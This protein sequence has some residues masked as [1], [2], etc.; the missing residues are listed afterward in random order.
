MAKKP[1]D[2]IEIQ[3][4]ALEFRNE[5]KTVLLAS[6]KNSENDCSYAPYFCDDQ[7]MLYIFVSQLA[8]HTQ[9]IKDNPNLGL[10]FIQ[11]E[12]DCRNLFARKRLTLNANVTLLA[13]SHGEYEEI[14]DQM[15]E[16]HGNM[17]GMLRQLPDFQLFKLTPEKGRFV[18]GFGNAWEVEGPEL[19][20][21]G[22]SK[23]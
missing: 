6:S 10:M 15:A 20:V 3:Q 22:L 1:D 4:E 11:S 7:G 5:F 2:P 17:I 23:G 16:V 12:A 14:L 8:S 19:K 9:N 21:L 13:P 18:R